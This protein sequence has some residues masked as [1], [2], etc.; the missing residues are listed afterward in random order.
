MPTPSRTLKACKAPIQA[1]MFTT[2]TRPSLP[3][4]SPKC[5]CNSQ[6]TKPTKTY[7][8]Q[9]VTKVLSN[10]AQIAQKIKI[11]ISVFKSIKIWCHLQ[12]MASSNRATKKLNQNQP[13]SSRNRSR[14]A[15]TIWPRQSKKGAEI[16]GYELLTIE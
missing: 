7:Q 5:I 8:I 16:Y 9:K 4:T 15:R 6:S 10:L 13:L 1:L 2:Q 11:K 3:K 14:R 12:K